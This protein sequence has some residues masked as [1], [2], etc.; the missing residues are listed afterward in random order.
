MS[1]ETATHLEDYRFSFGRNWQNFLQGLDIRR[2]EEAKESLLKNLKRT[3][4]NGVS[5]LDIGSG[6]G[7]FSLAARMLGAKVT[8]FDFDID[9]VNCAKTLK[10]KFFPQDSDWK[11]FQGSVL[12]IPFLESLGTFDIVYSWGVLHH[13]GSMWDALE[14]ASARV[15]PNG[16]LFISIYNDMGRM[17][18]VWIQIKKLYNFLPSSLRWIVLLFTFP[19][20]WFPTM[21]LDFVKHFNPFHTW[22]TYKSNRGM[23]PWYDLVDWVGGYPFE[24]ASPEQIF[25]FF[26][27]KGYDLKKLRTCSGGI[28]CNEFVFKKTP[29][30]EIAP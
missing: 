25:E 19:R 6:S 7:L 24:V 13:T 5:F 17:T 26:H 30:L 28:G 21:I 27:S 8:S 29:S 14:N 9:S 23:S 2:I 16:S 1:T 22:N 3:D 18:S 11:I 15:N 20:L 4:L 12:D 10:K